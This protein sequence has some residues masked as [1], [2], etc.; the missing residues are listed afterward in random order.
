MKQGDT[1]RE[2][3]RKF[4]LTVSKKDGKIRVKQVR[5]RR[6]KND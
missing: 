1:K 5:E 4:P 6:I 3:K 2:K